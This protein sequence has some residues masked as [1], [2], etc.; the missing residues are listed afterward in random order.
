MHCVPHLKATKRKISRANRGK[1]HGGI[2]IPDSTVRA[3]RKMLRTA[4]PAV[5][6]AELGVNRAYISRIKRRKLRRAVKTR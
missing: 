5:I 1:P 2:R 4:S 3:I 6:A